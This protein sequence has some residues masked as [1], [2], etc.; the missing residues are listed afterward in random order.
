MLDGYA[1]AVTD[2]VSKTEGQLKQRAGQ[3]V[4]EK[5][6]QHSQVRAAMPA[7]RGQGDIVR[8]RHIDL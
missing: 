6:V 3:M 4:V 5:V 1:C 2:S 7:F 8:A